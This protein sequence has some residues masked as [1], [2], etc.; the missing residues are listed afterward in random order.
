MKPFIP[1]YDQAVEMVK[2]KGELVFYETKIN[3][4]G[5]NISVFNYRLAGY[6]DFITPVDGK[7]YDAKEMR[8]ICYVFNTDGSLFSHYIMLKKFWN[9]NQVPETQLN[10]LKEKKIKS[11]YNKEDG[12]LI[13][14][15]KLPNGKIIAKTKAGFDN[16]QANKA[17]EFLKNDV[18]LYAFVKFCIKNNLVPFFEYVSFKNKIVLHYH[19]TELI[20]L[21]VRNNITGDFIDVEKF[22]G[23]AGIKVV[24]SQPIVSLEELMSTS[25]TLKGIE[26]WVIN[27]EDGDMVKQKTLEYW[28]LHNLVTEKLNRE[29]DVISMILDNTIDDAISQLNPENDKERIDWINDIEN[30]I[31]KYIDSK[32]IEV[33]E[34]VTEYSGDV[35]PFAIKNHK[36]PNFALA[37]LFIKGKDKYKTICDLVLKNTSKLESAREFLRNI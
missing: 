31:K 36:H 21:K 27:F 22:R 8:G 35:K 9:I 20:L 19:K 29:N 1:T 15:I 6:N 16:D 7:D 10:I 25:E 37:L 12:S 11:I 14:F 17:N 28:N 4:G 34:L 3:I 26:G 33:D 23:T 2:S 18:Y 32:I 30:K 24:Q 5:F 13:S